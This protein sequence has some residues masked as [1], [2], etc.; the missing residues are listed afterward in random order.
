MVDI[1][2]LILKTQYIFIFKNV[3]IIIHYSLNI[4]NIIYTYIFNI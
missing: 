4:K 2:S 1:Y 3:Q